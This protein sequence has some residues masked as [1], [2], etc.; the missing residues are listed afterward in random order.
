M[1][2]VLYSNRHR[3]DDNRVV[4]LEAVHLAEHGH[5]VIVYAHNEEA[6]AKYDNIVNY[7]CENKTKDCFHQC[8]AANGDL[9]IFHD[10]G[11][12]SLAVKLQKKGKVCLF[13]SHENYEEKL[14]SRI[15]RKFPLLAPFKG[16]IAK[17]WWMYEHHCVSQ[18]SGRICADRTV[19][20]KY[21]DRTFLLP[22]M[23]SREFFGNLPQRVVREDVHTLIYVGTITWDR[24]II[25]AAEA[26]QLCTHSN[27]QLQV[28]GDTKDEELKKKIQSYANVVWNGRVAW[29]NLTSHLVNADIGIVLLQPTEAYYYCP[30]ENIVKLWEYMSVGLPILISDFPGLRKLNDELHFGCTVKPDDVQEIAKQIDWMIDHPDAV[31]Q[32]GENGRKA[33]IENYNAENYTNSLEKYLI[34]CI[35]ECS[36]L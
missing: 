24:G 13:D 20:E 7:Q 16:I 32:M 28:I 8:M 6:K 14:K 2:I 12:L 22:N 19:V 21:G 1:K 9:Y 5:Q 15:P 25:E 17:L 35:D 33:V 29:R 27:V 34:S 36:E 11:L 23:P 31:K 26:I 18:L 30:G 3:A 4:E 10:P